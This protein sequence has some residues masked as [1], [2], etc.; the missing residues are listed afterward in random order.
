[1]SNPFITKECDA[2]TAAKLVEA[3]VGQMDSSGKV[4]W[5]KVE[6]EAGTEVGYSRG[7]LVVRWA[8]LA[9]KNPEL[10]F[11]LAAH[12]SEAFKQATAEGKSG[13]FDAKSVLQQVVI[14]MRDTEALSWGE[15]AVRLGI[16]ESRVRSAYRHN[17][18]RKDLGLRI[19]KGG[20]FAYDDG[21]LYTDNRKAEGAHIPL[22]L[23]A[24]PKVEQ[25]L[26]FME[27]DD[28]QKGDAAKRKA[29]ITRLL[30]VQ[31]LLNNAATPQAQRQAQQVRFNELLK[32]WN[33][34]LQDLARAR[35]A[36]GKA[37]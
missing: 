11:D 6:A 15:I 30:K 20:R 9:E 19:N 33:V 18:I 29:A 16:P 27:K 31:D 3:G 24:K 21:S 25:L 23:K 22:D 7:W 4:P 32:K 13:D 1:M 10:L 36:K 34:T 35:A 2:E 12:Q 14:R 8:Y 37:A 26:N 28:A 5:A 17:G